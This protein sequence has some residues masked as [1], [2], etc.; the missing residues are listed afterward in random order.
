MV[1]YEPIGRLRTPYEGAA[2]F[3]PIPE[4]GDFAIDLD[5]MYEEGLDRLD[6]FEYAYVLFD[7]DRAEGYSLSVT[8]PW[9]DRTVGLFATRAPRRP[10]PIGLSVVRITGIEDGRV[11][12]SAIDAFDGTPV[13]DLKPYVDGL[14]S[15]SDA[16][17]GWIDPDHADDVEHLELHIKGIP[18]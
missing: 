11:D 15:K 14:D 2:P 5:P 12:I 13:L 9:S 4:P 17:V 16:D 3:Q 8:P 18:H 1:E 7:L 6:A 10:N